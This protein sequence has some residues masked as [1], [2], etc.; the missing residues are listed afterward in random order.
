GVVDSYFVVHAGPGAEAIYSS[1]YSAHF[2]YFWSH[3]GLINPQI[4]DGVIVNLYTLEPEDGTIGVFC[5]EYGHELGLSDLYDIDRS[6]EGIGEWGLMGSGGW[7]RR[8]GD[9][10]G[11]CPAHLTAWSKSKLGWLD[12]INV[13]SRLLNQEIPPVETAA[14]AFKLWRNGNPTYEYFLVENR[15]NIGFDAGLT[16]RQK[17]L[18]LPDANGLIIYHIDESVGHNS[19]ELHKMVDVEEAS[20]LFA[21]GTIPYENLDHP[22]FLFAYQFLDSGNRGDNGD[23]FPGYG[24]INSFRTD[25]VGSR[26][27][28]VFA[29]TTVPSSRDYQDRLTGVAVRNIRI[30]GQNIVADLVITPVTGVINASGKGSGAIPGAVELAQ[31]YPNPFNT[32]TVIG[33][34]IPATPKP[35][36]VVIQV[37]D[38]LGRE[39]KTLL[40]GERVTGFWQTRWDGTNNEGKRVVSG[41]Y[42]YKLATAGFSTARKMVLLR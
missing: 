7:N 19:N 20:S 33:F 21:K 32:L 6:S 31:N 8:S 42:W 34:K 35:M 23:P 4:R 26:D 3:M 14:M 29:D 9:R 15:Q 10:E 5:H 39:V 40:A 37:Y 12:P 18:N 30:D 27:R 38:I 2:N 28:G 36:R 24:Q 1:N 22:R 11:T 16:R 17:D 25:F 41:I 13:S